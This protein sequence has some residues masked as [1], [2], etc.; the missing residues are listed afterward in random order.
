MVGLDW[1]YG[2]LYALGVVVALCGGMWTVLRRA[3]WI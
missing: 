2:E 1:R 3:R